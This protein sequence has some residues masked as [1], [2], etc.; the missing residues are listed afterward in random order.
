MKILRALEN[1]PNVIQM[2]QDKTN[3]FPLNYN[4]GES[5]RLHESIR[6]FQRT[7]LCTLPNLIEK[8][9]PDTFRE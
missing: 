1:I 3:S 7:L 6:E 8:L 2:A 4:Q 5:I 9:N